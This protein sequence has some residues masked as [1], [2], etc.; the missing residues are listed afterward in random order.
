MVAET[1]FEVCIFEGKRKWYELVLAAIFYSIS[2][3]L[4][5]TAFYY[6]FIDAS[7]AMFIHSFYLTLAFGLYGLANGL[8][9]STTKNVLIDTD[10][11]DIISRYCVGP[12]SYDVKTKANEFEYISF[13][14][15]KNDIFGTHLW[16]KTNRHYKMYSF[17]KKESAYN[18]AIKIATK[19]NIDVLD[20]TEKGNSK[21]I[22]KSTL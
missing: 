19:L 21:W 2:I 9:F 15:D 12:F 3:Y 1:E 6:A 17:D 13:F 20:A 16:Y 8:R 7:I 22:D 10:T 18:F 11:N 5:F 4:L 14:K